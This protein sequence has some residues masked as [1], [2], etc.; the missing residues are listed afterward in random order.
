MEWLLVIG[1][2]ALV[3]SLLLLFSR[4]LIAVLGEVFNKPVNF[5]DEKLKAI[6]MP[7]GIAMVIIGGWIIS[8][9]FSYSQ[10]WYLHIVGTLILLFGLLYLFMPG[11]LDWL[12]NVSSLLLMST[13]EQIIGAR[14]SLGV[15][16]LVSAIYLFYSAFLLTK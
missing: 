3:F 1:I 5:I 8:V 15:I 10:L 6:R 16:L 12:S 13:D 9:A 14:K 2:I 4:D 11:W 7:A